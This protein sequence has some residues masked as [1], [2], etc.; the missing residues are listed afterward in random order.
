MKLEA[1]V[2]VGIQFVV[3]WFR[4]SI[5]FEVVRRDLLP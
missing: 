3:L 4:N 5:V 1:F 2:H